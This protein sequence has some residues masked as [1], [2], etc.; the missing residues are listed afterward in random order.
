LE[1]GNVVRNEL[2]RVLSHWL[3]ASLVRSSEEIKVVITAKSPIRK[4][5][6]Q[7]NDLSFNFKKSKKKKKKD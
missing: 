5:K 4:E 7:T 2:A 6:S 3:M 1:N